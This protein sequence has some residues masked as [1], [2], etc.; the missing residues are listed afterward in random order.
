MIKNY[1][2]TA[3][4]N[5][6]RHKGFSFI[7]ILGLALSMSICML[8]IVVIVDQLK[9]DNFVTKRERIYRI[10]S[11]NN[12]NKSSINITKYA[13]TTY[14]LYD[15]LINNYAIVE[16]A[17]VL[18]NR[19]HRDAIFKENKFP[20]QGLYAS[21]SFFNL[22]DFELSSNS[23]PNPLK[24]PFSIIL[25][26]ETAQKYFKDENPIGKFLQVDTLGNFKITGIIP[27]SN[28][29]SQFQFQALVSASTLPVLEASNKIYEVTNN[30]ESFGSSYI[31]IL[32][33][34]N[35]NLENVTSTLD[36]ISLEKYKDLEE[37]NVSFY[38]KPFN[39]VVPG[40]FIANEIGV[41]L[42]KVFIIFLAGLSL[43][44]IISAAFNYTSLSMARSLL[45]AKEV[46]VR[47]T[48]GANRRQVIFQFLA[49]AILVAIFALIFGI[50]ILQ[51]ILPGFSGMKMMSMLEIR[52]EQ[53]YIV[54][55]V[56][57]VFALLTGFISGILP[58]V[59]ISSFN[60][61]KVL[62]GVSNI[63][64]LSKITLRKILLVTQ[65]T[66]SMIFI[67]SIIAIY[68]Q[69]NYMMN[70]KMGFNRDVVYNIWL[71]DNDFEIV[72][73][74]Y[75][76]FPEVVDISGSTHVPGIG[77]L[78]N[79]LVR[80]NAEDEKMEVDYFAVDNKYID[81]MGLELIKG[82]NFP[83]EG[84]TENESFVIVDERMIKRFNLGTPT[85]AIGKSIIINDSTLVEIIGVIKDYHYAALFLPQTSLLL[86]NK[87]NEFRL[88]ALKIAAGTSPDI[89][90]KFEKGWDNID[91]YNK[92]DG[93][94]LDAQIK[95][96][97]SYF[98]DILYT[99]G[100]A[101]L[102]AIVIA[103]LGLLGMA[104][105]STQ[106]RIKEIGVRKVFGAEPK[107]IV[108][109]ISKTYIKMFIVAAIIAA[110][111]AY[112]INNMWIQYI[113]DHAPFGFATIFLGLFLVIGFGMLTIAS[114]TLKAAN[115]NPAQ[116][117]RY[118]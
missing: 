68:S 71:Q 52:P 79:A 1:L 60:P 110:P 73:D 58:S 115:V 95:D 14:P 84:N 114:Q 5:I 75:T 81:V 67:V 19:F 10:E 21:E 31:Y 59:Y 87:P 89:V 25:Q 40:A 107:S 100:F 54:Y 112:L 117:L 42:P 46:G 86:R 20:I 109:L 94:F 111:L 70:A 77:N 90:T 53:D 72:K 50:I 6:L 3:F 74:Y 41:F 12:E 78:R 91:K 37:S 118:E 99:V 62:K 47:K 92:F 106:T 13:S 108:Y 8:I 2:L 7:N 66:F 24:E 51:F 22:F 88:A 83:E 30:W 27:K 102:L 65:F 64:I 98:E 93:D 43:I 29:K 36:K 33:D 105:Y 57:F 85:E 17:V 38:L 15:E 34:E 23:F 63:K 104:T 28:Y 101:S 116:S 76:Q 55:L 16:D 82:S 4:R 103:C 61:I 113:A 32:V 18:N 26:E 69:M 11:I 35:A 9:Y 48:L 80:V 49:E 44:I 39:K 96:Y 97:Y 56:F 45:R